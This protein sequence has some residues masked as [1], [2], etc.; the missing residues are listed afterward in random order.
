MYVS[1]VEY[2]LP[3]ILLVFSLCS[4]NTRYTSTNLACCSQ[5]ISFSTSSRLQKMEFCFPICLPFVSVLLLPTSTAAGPSPVPWL[6]QLLHWEQMADGAGAAAACAL[7]RF[8]S[9]PGGSCPALQ[10]HKANCA[11]LLHPVSQSHSLGSLKISI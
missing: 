7:Q 5:S 10:E 2:N 3:G 8:P 11:A 9:D 1:V 6:V 4:N